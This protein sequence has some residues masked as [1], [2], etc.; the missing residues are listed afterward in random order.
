MALNCCNLF[1]LVPVVVPPGTCLSLLLVLP[2][3]LISLL[4][5]SFC[6]CKW[7]RNIYIHEFYF[8]LKW[9]SSIWILPG[10]STLALVVL[11]VLVCVLVLLPLSLRAQSDTRAACVTTLAALLLLVLVRV[12][13]LVLALVLALVL[14]LIRLILLLL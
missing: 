6:Y 4:C 8:C 2:C 7:L 11:L 9:F 14:L 5:S 12:L 3:N 10:S 1:N 13:P